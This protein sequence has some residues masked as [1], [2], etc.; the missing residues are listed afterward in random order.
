LKYLPEIEFVHEHVA[1]D[2]LRL[3][4]LMKQVK[5]ERNENESG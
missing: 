1:E 4:E 5:I 2:A 3:N